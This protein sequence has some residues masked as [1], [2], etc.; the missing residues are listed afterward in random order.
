M[1]NFMIFMTL[2]CSLQIFAAN[3]TFSGHWAGMGSMLNDGSQG[4]NAISMEMT[5]V[6]TADKIQ[7]YDCWETEMGTPCY[8]STYQLVNGDQIYTNNSKIGDI[9]PYDM[10]IFNGHA[11][12]S[13]QMIFKLNEKNQLWYRYT[14]S[15]F[16]GKMQTRTGILDPL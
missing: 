1:K 16:D 7:I 4:T 13:E 15:S 8:K 2:F 11:Q 10:I 3:R 9:Y 14:F 12:A 6:Q 5:I